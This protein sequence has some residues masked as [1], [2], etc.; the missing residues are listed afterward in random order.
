MFKYIDDNAKIYTKS[1]QC[2][3]DRDPVKWMET[4]RKVIYGEGIIE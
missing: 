3:R 2:K 4:T 1:L